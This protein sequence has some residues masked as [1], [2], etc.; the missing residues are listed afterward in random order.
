MTWK[1]RPTYRQIGAALYVSAVTARDWACRGYIAVV[2]T[3]HGW[4]V[5]RRAEPRP[6]G[7]AP[8]PARQ[9]AA[10]YGVAASTVRWWLRTGRAQVVDGEVVRKERSDG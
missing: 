2:T 10:R 6:V 8:G 1:K 9:A 4:A 7:R 3:P 5:E